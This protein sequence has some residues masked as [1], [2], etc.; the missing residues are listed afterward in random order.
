VARTTPE[1]LL[2]SALLN[3]LDPAAAKEYG[4][5]P[6][7]FVGYR[8]EYEWIQ[9]FWTQQGSAP[10][11]SALQTAYP[12]FPHD[13]DT[14]DV[15]WPAG[16][17]RKKF[18]A[19]ELAKA[20]LRV[21]DLLSQQ[22]VE[23]AYEQIVGLRLE[24][25]STKPSSLLL[26]HAFLDDYGPGTEVRMPMPWNTLQGLTD[27][28]GPGELWY[29]AARQGHGKSSYLI[30]MACDSARKGHRVL[31]YSLEMTRRQVQVKS[32][33]ILGAMLG[34]EVDHREMLH[35]RFDRRAYK[36]LLQD[37]EERIPG[38]IDVHTP[39]LG[40]V[41]PGVIAARA[42]DYD[43]VFVDYIGLVKA[44][45]GTPAIKDYRVI[46][47]I[48][49]ELKQVALSK[50]TRIVAAAQINREGISTSGKAPRL[51][52]L[53]QSDHLGNDGDVVIT[54]ARYCKGV[55]ILSVEKN[56]HG[57]SEVNFWTRFEAN[58]GIYTEVTRDV[59]D[60][61]RTSGDDE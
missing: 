43:Q 55:N 36:T 30:N 28:Q 50:K 6:K 10:S 39:D 19:R 13:P 58:R 59:A 26:D 21:T 47:E 8:D 52:H 40:L 54:Q 16:E 34:H 18:A 4:I 48:S 53:A 20:T 17:V 14:T 1:S 3:N 29:F 35:Q 60:E 7:H 42:G 51:H 45:D 49:N 25:V 5:L 2:L 11:V 15:R 22:K 12:T 44:D 41:T 38:T 23:E 37:I 32:H 24:T 33:S 57:T 61:I 46:A 56:R 31:F 9:N 27:G